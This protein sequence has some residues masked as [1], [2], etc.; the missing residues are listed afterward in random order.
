MAFLRRFLLLHFS[1]CIFQGVFKLKGSLVLVQY[2]ANSKHGQDFQFSLHSKGTSVENSSRDLR[3]PPM[4]LYCI[5]DGV[6]GAG[7]TSGTGASIAS[8]AELLTCSCPTSRD[9]GFSHGLES[10]SCNFQLGW[11][12]FTSIQFKEVKAVTGKRAG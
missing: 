1:G 3:K 12:G 4:G 8:I 2:R 11:L 7:G 5:F 10:A 6:A 9:F